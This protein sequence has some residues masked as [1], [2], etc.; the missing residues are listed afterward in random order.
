MGYVTM[1][2]KGLS[3]CVTE[4]QTLTLYMVAAATALTHTGA[5]TLLGHTEASQLEVVVV[6]NRSLSR[7]SRS[8]AAF[9]RRSNTLS[10]PTAMSA[11]PDEELGFGS[12]PSYRREASLL[13]EVPGAKRF[14]LSF[15]VDAYVPVAPQQGD[16]V[17][18]SDTKATNARAGEKQA[19]VWPMY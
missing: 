1:T 4:W 3:M 9:S 2:I 17:A 13:Q 7:R 10:C 15:S 19:S 16:E 18:V 8:S 11:L 14:T 12:K 6:V 5:H